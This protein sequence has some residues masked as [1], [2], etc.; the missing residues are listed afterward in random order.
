MKLIF[1]GGAKI[2]TGA[3]YFLE[4]NGFKILIDC[5]L[6]QGSNYSERQNFEPF[7]Y[8]PADIS[9]VFVTHAHIDHTGR[10]PKLY[11]DGFRGKVY[12]TFPTKDFSRL[13][14]EDSEH[15]LRQEAERFHKP[16]LYSLNDVNGLINVWEGVE[17][18]KKIKIGPFEITFYD[19]GHILGSAFILV[20]A[21][22]KKIVFSGDLGNSPP[23]II[24]PTEQ[25][26]NA[27]YAVMES[28]YGG[29]LHEPPAERKEALEDAIEDTVKAGGVLL[30]P[31]FA[32]ER[33]QHLLFE[34][35]DLVEHGRIPKAPVFI[36][37]PLAIKL[38]DVYQKYVKYWNEEAVKQTH[39][40]DELFKFPG[41][42]KTL[43]TEESKS[44]NNVPP[45][46]IIIAGSG[47]SH[48]GRILHHE[49]R[50]FPDPKS[51]ILIIGYQAVGSLGRQILDGAKTV[52]MF[53]E[54]IP[55]RCRVKAIGGYSAH[56][57]Q[58]GLL[59][60][61]NPMRL[62][63][64]KVFLVQGEDDQII[65]LAQKIKDELAVEAV[66]PSPNDEF[67]I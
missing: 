23:P 44:I 6:Q 52:K 51:V 18:H 45:P 62:N 4:S 21:E 17:Y 57:D 43:T 8:N 54:E 31:A 32:M 40:G 1:Y 2:V 27:D 38:T 29:R 13:L 12:S 10:L 49:R 28:T 7:P 46:K 42:K 56:A 35:N 67:I 15:I 58:K 30:I 60:W 64:K 63:L 24:R 25:L 53:G 11:K 5:G 59:W 39:S 48:G 26:E 65:P 22:G 36:D 50:Y 47:M 37:S 19:A 41:L 34:L 33:T 3:N 66:A 55:V 9:A 20:E 16:P 61:L 14:L